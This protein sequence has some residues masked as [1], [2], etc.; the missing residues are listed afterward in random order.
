MRNEESVSECEPPNNFARRN[1]LDSSEDAVQLNFAP[2]PNTRIG[3]EFIQVQVRSYGAGPAPA[4]LSNLNSPR[5]VLPVGV[6]E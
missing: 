5:G 6:E 4:A 3:I 1:P 2:S